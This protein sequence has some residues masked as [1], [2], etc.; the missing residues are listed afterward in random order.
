MDT[1]GLLLAVKV[2]EASLGDREGGYAL[3]LPLAGKLPRLQ[4]IWVDSGYAGEPFKHWVKEHLG[5]RVEIVK[6]RWTG[7]RGVWA[8]EGV[9]IDW[10]T[11]LPKG[12]HV[13]PRRW[14]VERT[15]SQNP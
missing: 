8:P 14:V 15:R 6:H 2:L 5:V 1:Q 10:D 11:V 13:L 4:L 12:F 9:E 7:L 3:L